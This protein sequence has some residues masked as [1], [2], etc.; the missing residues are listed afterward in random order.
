MVYLKNLLPITMLTFRK[1]ESLQYD[2]VI[3][4]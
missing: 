1:Y 2:T 4:I 3:P